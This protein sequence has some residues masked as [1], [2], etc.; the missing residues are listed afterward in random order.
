MSV[1]ILTTL[2]Q[3]NPAERSQ[4]LVDFIRQQLADLLELDSVEEIADTQAFVELGTDSMQAVDFKSRLES[5]LNCSLRTTLV[6]D[7]P[8]LDILADYLLKDV[9]QLDAQALWIPA[10]E[11]EPE[12]IRK[13]TPPSAQPSLETD[14]AIVGMA[15][16]F[17][18]APTATDLWNRVLEGTYADFAHADSI[19]GLQFGTIDAHQPNLDLSLLGLSAE[20]YASLDRSQQLVYQLLAVI[21]QTYGLSAHELS[22]QKTGVFLATNPL[23]VE[24]QTTAY[25]IPLSNQVSFQLNWQ[26]P[27]ESV[28]TFCTSV[29]VALHRAIQSMHAGECTHALIGGINLISA[30]NFSAVAQKGLYS[31][32]LSPTNQTQSFCAQASGFVR[33]EGAGL[34]MLKPLNAAEKD[35][36]QILAVIKSS[37]VHHGGRGFSPEAPN[38]QGMKETIRMCFRKAGISPDTID[39][40]EAHGIGNL[41][42][43]T[44]EISAIHDAYRELGSQPDKHWHLSSVKPTVGHPEV[45]AGMA[46]LLKAV[47]A[48]Q[49]QTIP[50]LAGLDQPNPELDPYPALLLSPKPVFWKNSPT[51]RRVALNSYAIGGVNAHLIL[52]EYRTDG[53]RDTQKP[54]NEKNNSPHLPEPPSVP[55][56][57]TLRLEYQS[58]LDALVEEVLGRKWA[59][60]DGSLSP[61][62]YGFDSIQLVQLVR[63]LNEKLGINLRIG[64]VLAADTLAAFVRILELAEPVSQIDTVCEP[65]EEKAFYPLSELQKGLWYIQQTTPKS[66]SFNVPLVCRC[67]ESIQPE[68]L[69]QAFHWLLATYPALRVNFIADADTGEV[70]QVIQP[71]TDCPDIHWLPLTAEQEVTQTV[72]ALLRQPFRLDTE[73]LVRLYVLQGIDNQDS[74]VVFVIHHSV[75]DGISGVFLLR[76]FWE[77]YQKLYAGKPIIVAEQDWAFF[78]FLDWEKAYLESVQAEEDLNWWKAQLTGVAP[79]L[80]LPYDR[81]PQPSLPDLGV[82]CETFTLTT[83][84]WEV[85]RNLAKS[86]N[87]NVSVLLLTVFTVFLHKL[88]REEDIAVTSPVQGRPKQNHENSIG[89]YINLMVTRSYVAFDKTFDELVAQTRQRFSSGMDHSYYPCSKLLSSLGLT[90]GSAEVPLP[91]SYSYQ[92]IFDGLEEDQQAALGIKTLYTAYQETTDQYTLEVYD[93][94]HAL[95]LHL[96]YKRSLFDAATIARHLTYFQTLLHNILTNPRR[97]IKDYT[98][99][100]DTEKHQLLA[101]NKTQADYPQEKC[102]HQLFESQACINPDQIALVCEGQQM[103]YLELEEKSRLLAVYLQEQGIQPD[104][105]VGICMERSS[106][107]VVAVLGILRA[108]GAYIPIDPTY[109]PER[110]RYMLKDSEISVLLTQARLASVLTPLCAENAFPVVYIDDNWTDITQVTG[111]LHPAATPENLAYVI[112]TSGSTGKPKGVMIT[113]RSLVNLSQALIQTYAITT[114][115]RVLQFA[116]LSFD[117][118]VEE[119]FPYLM[120]GAGI[121][122]RQQEDTQSDRFY[123]LVTQTGVTILNL[124]PLFYTVIDQLPEEEKTVL[125]AQVRLMSL[126]GEA[127]PDTILASAQT[128][129][130]QLF[131]AYGPT[132]YTV[133]A[134]LA[135]VTHRPTAVIGKPL[136]NTQLYVLGHG[137]SLQPMGV[138]GELHIAGDGLARGYLNRDE[139]TA[140]KFIDNPFGEGWLYKTGDLVRWLPDGTLEYIGR[141]DDQVKIRGFRVE[142]GEIETVLA[143]HPSV[144][145]AVV[146]SQKQSQGNRLIAYWIAATQET[147][148]ILSDADLRAWLLEKLPDYMVPSAFVQLENFPLTSSGKADRKTLQ[149]RKVEVVSRAAYVAPRT[150]LESYLKDVW[151]EILGVTDVGVHDN[152]FELGGHS[153]LSIQLVNKTLTRFRNANIQVVDILKNPTIEGLCHVLEDNL[154]EGDTLKADPY[155]IR[156]RKGK[157]GD[158]LTF[159]VPGMPGLADGYH[160]LAAVVPDNDPV[161]GLQMKGFMGEVPLETIEEMAQHNIALIRS[162]H[163]KGKIS[164][165]T[166]SYGGAVVYEMLRQLVGQELIIHRAVLIECSTRVAI[167]TVTKESITIFCD[168]IVSYLGINP[169]IFYE[170]VDGIF[171]QPKD[172]WKDLLLAILLDSEM[173]F[174]KTILQNMITFLDKSVS[175]TYQLTEKLPYTVDIVISDKRSSLLAVAPGSEESWD[176]YFDAVRAISSRGDHV[177]VIREPHVSEWIQEL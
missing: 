64:Q 103:T 65:V 101:F 82:G 121:V 37:A 59:D 120:A 93:F 159:I 91:I 84:E 109:A 132:E 107:M 131:N 94:R 36:N 151:E 78:D 17:P 83:D 34:V 114:H 54:T 48:L 9:L 153:L 165:Y 3:N 76:S 61:I 126:G 117:M 5:Q 57:I 15:G 123:R 43:D 1:A 33:S 85:V 111:S 137:L 116:S 92:N 138:T 133:N 162:M 112:Y 129:G 38:V 134:A 99:L 136:N 40:I 31:G 139:L 66:T 45:A 51:L 14:I 25:Q 174:N 171:S 26:G 152:F 96:K 156:L 163:P 22:A 72:F 8:R 79:C 145:N 88:T 41:L 69:R 100:P 21:F 161:Y 75:M 13:T 60:L 176:S 77:M 143:S 115:D 144:A 62:H 119:I 87:V 105:R 58:V 124:P 80:P 147:E 130:I 128:Q 106:D 70:M 164:L 158:N 167:T 148:T 39:Y 108:G 44:L 98:L 12:E 42:A 177:S 170:R 47:Q 32:L 97:E 125:F 74:H 168:A 49:H 30:Q 2:Q 110:I 24:A 11:P 104:S 18:T 7:Y 155:I 10:E 122:I 71:T 173:Q 175:V 140:E 90:Q 113:H 160:E 172:Q 127:L 50:G 142:V 166:H 157:D 149:A 29:Y 4:V 89:C 19:P 73:P 23:P 154:K 81:L 52:E 102:I 16:I 35:G 53:L 55:K 86:L 141:L 68:A 28:H 118:S 56:P 27:S 135:D 63:R 46:S 67:T 146:V 20:T 150:M 95:Q 6:F 169:T